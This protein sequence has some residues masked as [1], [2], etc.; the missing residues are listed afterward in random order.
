[1]KK[2]LDA[3]VFLNSI[4]YDDEKAEKCKIIIS[5]VVKKELIAV[6]SIL[7]WDEI[8]YIIGKNLGRDICVKEGY[9]FLRLPNLILVDASKHIIAQAQELIKDYNLK[10]RD[11]IHIATAIS[12][13]CTEVISDDA[14]FDNIKEIKRISP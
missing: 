11:A 1:M 9:Q 13:N 8:V 12:Q 14:D 3:N 5:K 4:L 2:Y 6:T 10:P 7:T